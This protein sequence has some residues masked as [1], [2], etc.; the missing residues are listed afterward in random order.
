M[1][2]IKSKA[3]YY[4]QVTISL[5]I[6]AFFLTALYAA[7]KALTN[8]L[9]K[10]EAA[11]KHVS[12]QMLNDLSYNTEPKIFEVSKILPLLRLTL[13]NKDIKL[14]KIRNFFKDKYALDLNIYKFSSNG[15]LVS[16]TPNRPPDLW[17]MKKIS[18]ALKVH[19]PSKLKKIR[20]QLNKK[21]QFAFGYGK[22]ID[23]LLEHPEELI[24]VTSDEKSGVLAWSTRKNGNVIIYCPSLP[25][26]NTIFSKYSKEITYKDKY[27]IAGFFRKHRLRNSSSLPIQAYD[28][29]SSKSNTSGKFANLDWYFLKTISGR[30]VF[31]AFEITPN[32]YVKLRFITRL[33]LTGFF[34]LIFIWYQGVGRQLPFGLTKLVIAAFIASA[35]V[36]VSSIIANTS[37]NIS[38]YRE[39][40]INRVRVF[41]KE[42]LGNIS[43]KFDSYLG[44]ATATLLKLTDK[45]IMGKSK[46]KYQKLSD[47]V[48]LI[49]PDTK[50]Y[51]RNAGA[52]ILFPKNNVRSD[53]GELVF[54]AMARR[55]VERYLPERVNEHKYNGNA[56]ADILVRKDDMGLSTL[57]NHP[58]QIQMVKPG[59][60]SMLLMLKT[61]DRKIDDS[62]IISFQI[63][64]EIAIKNYLRNQ[65]SKVSGLDG[66]RVYFYA[67]DPL[68]YKWIFSPPKRLAKSFLRIAKISWTT[69]TPQTSMIHDKQTGKYGLAMCVKSTEL[70]NKCL[71]AYFPY[72]KIERDLAKMKKHVVAGA[73]ISIFMIII[74]AIWISRQFINPL[75]TLEKGVI[76]LSE[77]KF[78]AQL[79]V[80]P[81]KDEFSNL[82]TAF[83]EMMAESY[84]M[85]VAKSV[86]EGLVPHEFP[87]VENYSLHG[88]LKTA[89]D[90]GGDCLDCFKLPNDNLLFLIGDITGHGVGSALIMAF[91]RAITFHWSQLS[92][93]SPTSL[94]E[95]IDN[96]LRANTTTR[97]FM[98]C[99]CGIL[100]VEN[101]E[102]NLVTKG[103]I[104]PM[105]ITKNKTEM[106]WIGS[107]SY[108]M[109]IGKFS[110][111]KLIK[112][113]MNPG[114]MLVSVTDGY[115]EA[116]N[117]SNEIVGFE[118]IEKWVCSSNTNNAFELTA[119]MLSKFKL[120]NR[121]EQLDDISMFA[122]IREPAGDSNVSE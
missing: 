67:L 86:Q 49:F 18:A 24:P 114:D 72:D 60:T 54:K 8:K 63:D 69:E 46:S 31:T 59:A 80:P 33:L 23:S 82:F 95:E 40:Q 64:P 17:L 1:H 52:E 96:M 103:H 112:F 77:R 28:Y 66:I 115:L 99:V 97:M 92:S 12:I 108:P 27:K 47:D 38:T 89:S 105:L 29:L 81:G 98:G 19:D 83:N 55:M 44:S 113:K 6:V 25:S 87:K 48:N 74:I 34:F 2:S 39:I 76:A 102:V 13:E 85:Q 53:G 71:I 120:W 116:L 22:D 93:L 50:V 109:G 42:F 101:N 11:K 14:N 121:T 68:K 51:V 7:E 70:D 91:S 84:D 32:I 79:N 75:K 100:D 110:L 119:Y 56:F 61:V 20:K 118:R 111:P 104:Y 36:P 122:L 45:A 10:T 30:I 37:E 62:A 94:V 57:L 35:L 16:K 73:V 78:D 43:Q 88:I 117:A 90:L 21:I 5:M 58:N 106:N 65:Y 26:E 3:T 9:N 15:K 41:Q 107:P 4:E